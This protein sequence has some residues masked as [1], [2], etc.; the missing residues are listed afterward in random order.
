MA[1]IWGLQGGI[2]AQHTP[3]ELKQTIELSEPL[4][5]EVIKNGQYQLNNLQLKTYANHTVN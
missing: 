3:A 5:E 4:P 1:A 2:E